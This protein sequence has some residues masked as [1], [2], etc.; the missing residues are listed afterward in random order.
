GETE[1]LTLRH[2]FERRGAAPDGLNGR[3]LFTGSYSRVGPLPYRGFA[4]A[5]PDVDWRQRFRHYR[6]GPSIPPARKNGLHRLSSRQA[7][8]KRN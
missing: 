1:R 6:D 4:G 5:L 7:P 2:R 3:L 8:H